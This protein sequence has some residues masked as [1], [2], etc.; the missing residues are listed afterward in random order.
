V[1]EKNDL[2]EASGNKNETDKDRSIEK[3]G[4]TCKATLAIIAELVKDTFPIDQFITTGER[5]LFIPFFDCK[6][7]TIFY[8]DPIE[9]DLVNFV[10][11]YNSKSSQVT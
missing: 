9:F 10:K 3:W 6:M 8:S 5:Q 1:I 4:K 11:R 2:Q 7:L